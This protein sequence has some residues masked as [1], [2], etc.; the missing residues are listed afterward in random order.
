MRDIGV[1]RWEKGTEWVLG[2]HVDNVASMEKKIGPL[3][4][5]VFHFEELQ[6]RMV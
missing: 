3:D 6:Y 5:W 2:D 4:S 1:S